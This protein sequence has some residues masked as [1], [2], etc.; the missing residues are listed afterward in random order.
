MRLI[1]QM[2]SVALYTVFV[3]NLVFS[4]GYGASEA[5]RMA[6]KPYRLVLYCLSLSYFSLAASS[7]SRLLDFFDFIYELNS[8]YH[9]A[10]FAGVLV[11]VYLVTALFFKLVFGAEPKFLSQLGIT[12]LNT[13]VLSVPFINFRAGYS[14]FQSLGTSLGA[15]FAFFVAVVLI[16]AGMRKLAHN[17]DIPPAFQGT[18]VMFIYVSLLALAFS[19]FSGSSLF[20]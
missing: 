8:I 20:A 11:A 9:A 1:F 4:G 15:G 10:I 14:F 7:I 6:A 5:V 19:G 2:F 17:K 3:Q 16:G 13:L 12:A 18:P